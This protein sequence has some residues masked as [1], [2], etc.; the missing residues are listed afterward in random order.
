MRGPLDATGRI[1]STPPYEPLDTSIRDGRTVVRDG[2]HLRTKRSAPPYATAGAFVPDGRHLRTGRPAPPYRAASISVPGGRRRYWA[3]SLP[4]SE[5]EAGEPDCGSVCAG[6]LG[7]GSWLGVGV[8][9]DG[10]GVVREGVGVGFGWPVGRGGAGRGA[11]LFVGL[12]DPGPA[13]LGVLLPPGSPGVLFSSADGSSSPEG[14]L[15]SSSSMG[16][17][18][19]PIRRGPVPGASAEPPSGWASLPWCPAAVPEGLGLGGSSLTLMQPVNDMAKAEAAAAT[20]AVRARERAVRVAVQGEAD[21]SEEAGE[22]AEETEGGRGP[23]GP[24]AGGAGWGGR[25][26]GSGRRTDGTSGS[27][28]DT[29]D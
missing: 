20:A 15:R 8:G 19:R 24:A 7:G 1:R 21:P 12:S 9:S 18:E 16:P 26:A 25:L 22:E 17:V 3:P 2:R 13:P 10:A 29:R 14:V 4:G 6:L 23:G 11:L 28:A 5:A 27:G